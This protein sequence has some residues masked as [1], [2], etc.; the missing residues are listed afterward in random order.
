MRTDRPFG[1][2]FTIGGLMQLVACYAIAFFV[3][4]SSL[5]DEKIGGLLAILIT[6]PFV[7]CFCLAVSCRHL[8]RPHPIREWLVEILFSMALVLPP[9]FLGVAFLFVVVFYHPRGAAGL[10]RVGASASLLCLLAI[11]V[12]VH[13]MIPVTCPNCRRRWL[14]RDPEGDDRTFVVPLRAY[15]CWA[16][17]ARF[18]RWYKGPWEPLTEEAL[19]PAPVSGRVGTAHRRE[20]DVDTSVGGAHPTGTLGPPRG[21]RL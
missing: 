2:R 10:A 1:F 8:L 5:R 17:G 3:I 11:G 7:S 13:H 21:D 12:L 20:S 6:G 9:F 18:R 16:C 14:L 15:W 19:Q 4:V